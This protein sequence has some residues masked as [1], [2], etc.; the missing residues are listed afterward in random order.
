MQYSL[1][2]IIGDAG[3]HLVAARVINFFKFPCR[4]I[5]IDIGID[6]EIEIIDNNY[7]STSE[8][9]RC[10]IK[11]TTS[12]KFCLYID[13]EHMTYWNKM[14]MP[15]VVFLVHLETDKIYWHC[16]DEIEKYKKGKT[17]YV[18][19]FEETDVLIAA[20]KVRFKEIASIKMVRQIRKFYE[21]A[22]T[23]V[24]RDNKDFFDFDEPKYDLTNFDHFVTNS[25]FIRH[26]LGKAEK[27]INKH[28]FLEN[29][30]RDY[31][32]KLGAVN[33]YLKRVDEEKK[34]ILED[35]GDDYFDHLKPE[36]F[37]LD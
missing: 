28:K 8:F 7:K 3:E 18:V 1:T 34:Q 24:D 23:I 25:V 32:E 12:D 29:V 13:E 33:K 31:S 4:L 11:T 16:I 17:G 5:G 21:E 30:R 37:N 6:A 27:L 35:S 22:F 15:V 20:N 36:N 10:Q 2:N 26:A 14:S 19:N 9:I